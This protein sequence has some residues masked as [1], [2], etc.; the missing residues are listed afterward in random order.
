[1]GGVCTT[2]SSNGFS[3]RLL[4]AVFV[5]LKIAMCQDCALLPTKRS[6]GEGAL[7]LLCQ[8]CLQAD[9]LV[10]MRPCVGQFY[11]C[12]LCSSAQQQ[13]QRSSSVHEVA[14][15]SSFYMVMPATLSSADVQSSSPHDIQA[16]AHQPPFQRTHLPGGHAHHVAIRRDGRRDDW[17]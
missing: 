17:L 8:H 12:I 10:L 6:F 15:P 13:G 14:D 9:V 7:A 11:R 5:P 4:D 3:M 16:A 2:E 1:M